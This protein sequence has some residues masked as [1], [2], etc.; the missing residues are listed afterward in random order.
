MIAII[1]FYYGLDKD[2]KMKQDN[3]FQ[4]YYCRHFHPYLESSVGIKTLLS[5]FLV[6]QET[7]RWKATVIILWPISG[8][9]LIIQP[10]NLSLPD[11][12]FHLQNVREIIIMV[13]VLVYLAAKEPIFK[14]LY[15]SISPKTIQLYMCF[16]RAA[17]IFPKCS[18]NVN[19][20]YFNLKLRGTVLQYCTHCLCW[21][22]RSS[23][24]KMRLL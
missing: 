1:L 10:P 16:H 20:N 3:N 19:V 11:N 18:A 22:L 15:N 24:Q 9:L 17:S 14:T 8:I 6:L 12:G 5:I 4:P 21:S 13:A 2:P 7:T 23:L